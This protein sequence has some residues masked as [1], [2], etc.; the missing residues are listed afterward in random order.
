LSRARALAE[1]PDSTISLSE[2]GKFWWDGAI[3]GHLTAGSTPLAPAIALA[4]DELL[5]GASRAA[6]QARLEAWFSTRLDARLEPLLALARAA[7]ARA[8]SPTALP[9]QA[10][11]LAHQLVENFGALER[12]PLALPEKLGPVLRA[13]KPFGVWAGRHTIYLPKLL[14]P[15]AASLLALL[16]GV[17]TRQPQLPGPPMPGLTSFTPSGEP[18]E[19]LHAAGFAIVG[20]RAIRF[21]MLERVEKEL[22]QATISGADAAAIL[23]KLVSLLGTGND[24]ARTVL[25]ALGWRLTE[26]TDASPV[27]RRRK[28]KSRKPAPTK[29]RPPEH[30]PFAGLKELMVK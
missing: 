3:V 5:K 21:D 20:G 15:D 17:W 8:G 16:W 23:P 26:V 24:E 12:G 28:E 25:A 4:A 22:D 18:R 10:R 11:G 29:S 27:W 9:A 19:F 2:H 14:R 13:L 30:S 1:A 7:E 6:V